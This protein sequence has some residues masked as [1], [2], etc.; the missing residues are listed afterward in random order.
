LQY[1][2]VDVFSDRPFAGNALCVVLDPCPADLMQRVAREM[3]LSE[4]TFPTL[5][6]DHAYDT[7]IFTPN[8]EL[9]FAGHPTLGTAWVLGTGTWTQKSPGAT[10]TVEVD[11]AGARMTQ[12]EPHFDPLDA[13]PSVDAAG[14]P[15]AHGVW[16]AE[17]GGMHHVVVLTDAPIDE[18]KPDMTKIVSITAPYGQAT[19]AVVR[20]RDDANLHVRVFVPAAGIAEDPGTGSVAGPIGLLAREQWSTAKAITIHQGKEMGRPSTIEVDVTNRTPV[21]GGNVVR[22]A[23]GHLASQR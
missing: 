19:F 20:R 9:P 10:V 22:C 14:L 6:A 17:A 16:A 11:A 23:E 4:T 1:Q 7:R 18:L 2:V 8:A 5:T 3:N 12:P 13:A 15:G 21:V